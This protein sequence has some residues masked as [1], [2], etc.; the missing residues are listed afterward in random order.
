MSWPEAV[1]SIVAALAIAWIFGGPPCITIRKRDKH[2]E[3]RVRELEETLR[4]NGIYR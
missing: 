4:E 3:A 1:S 2:L